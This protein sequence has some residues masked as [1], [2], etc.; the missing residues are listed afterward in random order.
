MRWRKLRSPN[1]KKSK[2]AMSDLL[3]VVQH[4]DINVYNVGYHFRKF[5]PDT[6]REIR[7]RYAARLREGQETTLK[8]L[9]DEY[10]VTIPCIFN[11]VN[12]NSYRE[13]R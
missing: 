12:R 6:V 8:I 10:K 1:L 9:A 4:N 3:N 13:I 5:K 7:K 11:I 2:P